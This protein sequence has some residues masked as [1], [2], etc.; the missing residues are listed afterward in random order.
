VSVNGVVVY[1]TCSITVEENEMVVDYILKKRHVKVVETGLQVGRAGLTRYKER[2][3]HPSVANTRRFYP[4]VH[5][6]DGFYVAK[7]VKLAHGE[8]QDD[9]DEDV[10]SNDDEDSNIDDSEDGSM[11]VDEEESE[12]EEEE[13]EEEEVK[14]S[15]KSTAKNPTNGKPVASNLLTN[16]NNLKKRKVDTESESEEEEKVSVPSKKAASESIVTKPITKDSNA[17]KITNV[18]PAEV[19]KEVLSAKKARVEEP[20]TK[21]KQATTS[22]ST[23]A[24]DFDESKNKLLKRSDNVTKVT[25]TPVAV[26]A[27]KS[28]KSAKKT[29]KKPTAN[30]DSATEEEADLSKA[31]RGRLSYAMD[32]D[33]SDDDVDEDDEDAAAFFRASASPSR[34]MTPGSGKKPK[35]IRHLRQLSA[36]KKKLNA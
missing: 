1:S 30:T 21:V 34:R 18:A 36:T 9:D 27:D 13:E 10:S 4:H 7:I 2:R 24:R 23:P 20:E 16:T 14:P 17:N 3:F 29:E 15:K 28:T 19:P 6:M 11:S 5:N 12:E 25:A 32:E 22:A 35:S 33:D 26:E 31:I 8:R